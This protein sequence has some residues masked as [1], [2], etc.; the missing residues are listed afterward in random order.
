MLFIIFIIARTLVDLEVEVWVLLL[1]WIWTRY[2]FAVNRL[3]HFR[4][5]VF[6][7]GNRHIYVTMPCMF[8]G[9]DMLRIVLKKSFGYGWAKKLWRPRDLDSEQSSVVDP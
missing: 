9:R 7:H 5:S 4:K 8:R 6:C 2:I 1:S 3:F